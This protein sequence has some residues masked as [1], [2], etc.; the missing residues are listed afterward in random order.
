MAQ[1]QFTIYLYIWLSYYPYFV[2]VRGIKVGL[3]IR[4]NF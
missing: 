4:K 1:A 3:V 2:Q